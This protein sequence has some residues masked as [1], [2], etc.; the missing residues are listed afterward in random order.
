MAKSRA[1]VQFE[2]DTS[3]FTQGIREADKS[4]NTLRNELKL[5]SA[6]LRENGDTVD[7]LS[8][9]QDILQ[10]EHDESAKK[11]ANLEQKLQAARQ[12]F[13][14]ESTEVYNLT[15]R[16]LKAQTEFQ[17]I[18]NDITNTS[19]R[20]NDLENDTNDLTQEVKGSGD[21]FTIMKGAMADLV[22]GGIQFLIGGIGDLIGSLF[23]LTEATEEYRVMQYKLSGASDTFGYKVGWVKDQYAEFY[24]YLGDDQMATNAITNLMGL[25]TSTQNVSDLANAAIGVWSAYGDSIPI[26][27]LTESMNETAQVGKVTGT[28]ADALNWA[29]ISEDDFNTKLAACTSTQERAQLIADT[30]NG[31]YGESKQKFDEMG[32]SIKE[33]HEAELNLKDSQAELAEAIS[34]VQAALTN[35]KAGALDLIRPV[36]EAVASAFEKFQTWL[37]ANP[38]AAKILAAALIGLAT[39]FGILAAALGIQALIRGV[40]T[41]FALLNTTMLANPI[42]LIISAIAA[43]VAAFLYLWNN[44]E[45][46]RNFWIGVWNGI[47]S[48]FETVKN[49]I[50]TGISAIISF[51]KNLWNNIT[52]AWNGIKTTTSTVWNAIKTVISTVVNGIKNTVVTVFNAVKTAVSTVFNG[53]KSVATTVW[54][55][56]KN[57]IINPVETARD[58]VKRVI[59]KIRSF[60]NFS[61]SLPKLKLPHISIKGKFSLVPPSVPKFSIKWYKDGGIMTAPTMFGFNPKT[62]TAHVGGEAGAEAILPIERLETW[63]NRTLRQSNAEIAAYNNEKLDKLIAVAEDILAK[64]PNTYLD[65]MKVSQSLGGSSDITSGERMNL[66]KRGLAI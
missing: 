52:T 58:T 7:L 38:T 26:E 11:V 61:W 47:K 12:A 35:L 22:S 8:Q 36:I 65:G 40:Q 29:G 17:G 5:N 39:A 41:A 15:N 42:L 60:F 23:D 53:I 19:R 66:R 30:L 3:G 59:D 14:D 24:S 56:I 51:I 32:G 6:E 45:A 33:V 31:K 64:D 27:S 37:A 48:V 54:N 28:L 55:A 43:L 9:R 13:G 63:I 50:Q 34:P 62:N 16:L 1:Q 4:L 46:F 10:R 20:M 2:A 44:C 57:A 18:Q 25:G 49:A 21:G